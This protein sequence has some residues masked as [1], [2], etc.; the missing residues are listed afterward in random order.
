MIESAT[1]LICNALHSPLPAGD[2]ECFTL[3][4]VP[5]DKRLSELEFTYAFHRPFT[6]ADLKRLL[7]G[8]LR[9]RFGA[10]EY[11]EWERAV[12]GGFLNGLI[13]LVFEHRGKFYIVDWKTNRAGND[14]AN[15]SPERLRSEMWHT[16]YFMQYLIYTVAWVKYLRQ[17]LGR[18]E[19][20]DY[21]DRFGGV[22]YLFCLLYTS[23]AADD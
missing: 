21:R 2:G 4:E 7:A 22:F 23:D 19:E 8:F 13:D 18:F 5:A 15:F 9:E 10:V 14:L 3:A 20:T 11:P 1:E 16:F 12:S 6:T 17:R